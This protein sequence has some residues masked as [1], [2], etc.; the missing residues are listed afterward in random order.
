MAS[1]I[2]ALNLV[3]KSRSRAHV[4]DVQRDNLQSLLVQLHSSA[5]S[6]SSQ[7]AGLDRCRITGN[8][9]LC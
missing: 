7:V 8:R 3:M 5:M 6:S 4:G 1:S 2:E 9:I